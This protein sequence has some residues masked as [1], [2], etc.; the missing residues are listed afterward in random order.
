M[1][2]KTDFPFDIVCVEN[3]PQQRSRSVIESLIPQARR[4]GI[5]LS[6]YCQPEQ[7]I[8]LTRNCCIDRASGDFLAFID[9]DEFAAEDWLEQL[10]AV[11]KETQGDV[12]TG[13][14]EYQF[15][16]GFPEWLKQSRIYRP[17]LPIEAGL[18]T[19]RQ[20]GADANATLY[21]RE[22][23]SLRTPAFDPEFGRTGGG[24][25]DFALL[26][27]GLGKTIFKTNRARVFEMQ[28]PSRARVWFHWERQFREPSNTYRALRRHGGRLVAAQFVWRRF[29]ESLGTLFSEVPLLFV[30]PRQSLV[31]MGGRIACLLGLGFA[32][33]GFKKRGYR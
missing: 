1:R 6:Y 5:V 31:D 25:F 18:K 8:G 15:P 17:L 29:T 3:D 10:V 27:L 11:Q 28:P 7:N 16:D 20:N 12:I 32:V 33:L 13:V 30:H 26:L 23:F 9:D 21:R 22:L 24:D 19:I 14:V 4:Q 2:Q